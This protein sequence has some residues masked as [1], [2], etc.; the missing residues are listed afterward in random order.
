MDVEQKEI[1]KID[2]IYRHENNLAYGVYMFL[3][4]HKHKHFASYL[5]NRIEELRILIL[6]M[7]DEIMYKALD[8]NPDWLPT[9]NLTQQEDLIYLIINKWYG[10]RH[11]PINDFLP[12]DSSM[13]SR[14]MYDLLRNLSMYQLLDFLKCFFLKVHV[15]M[16][17]TN[18]KATGVNMI[19]LIST[20]FCTARDNCWHILRGIRNNDPTM[21]QNPPERPNWDIAHAFSD[22]VGLLYNEDHRLENPL[23]PEPRTFQ[24]KWKHTGYNYDRVSHNT[25]TK[26]YEK[27][28][29][30]M[31]RGCGISGSTNGVFTTA[32]WITGK[33]TLGKHHLAILILHIYTILCLDGGHSLV[34]V[35]A[36]LY[37]ISNYYYVNIHDFKD[38][39][40][41]TTIRNLYDMMSR[42]CPFNIH[43]S[44]IELNYNVSLYPN[45]HKNRFI[46]NSERLLD[47]GLKK[48]DF[49]IVSRISQKIV[50]N[51]VY[52]NRDQTVEALDINAINPNASFSEKVDFCAGLTGR[53]IDY[54]SSFIVADYENNLQTP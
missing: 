49:E 45:E 20:K 24:P 31:P 5:E 13:N 30:Y 3:Y 12:F 52:M 53:W 10:F 50:L 2:Q 41:E 23:K 19:T 54:I 40:N 16:L 32:L 15:Y 14:Q 51:M 35:L 6:D 47:Y 33:Q 29:L 25:R 8:D 1:F 43:E 26:T 42:I 46:K 34:E 27:F 39:L 4:K 48:K 22:K 17:F 44:A 36:A 37:L 18:E 9:L 21:N 11:Y 7:F 28:T 38:T